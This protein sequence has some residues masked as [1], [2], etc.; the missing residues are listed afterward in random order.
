[1]IQRAYITQW[2]ARA[3]WAL[4]ELMGTKLRALYQRRKGRDLFDLWIA[5]RMEGVAPN[6][7]V[8]AFR[9]YM[10]AEGHAVSRGEFE[11]NLA[12]KIALSSF[13]DDLRPLLAPGIHYDVA[14]A[15]GR[16]DRELLALL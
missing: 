11:R 13:V 15:A 2:R 3:P 10:D 12:E 14:E 8:A 9:R 1:M 16:I 7:I 5:L 4:D 6:R